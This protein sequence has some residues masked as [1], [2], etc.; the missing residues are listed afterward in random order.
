[1]VVAIL[2]RIIIIL[3]IGKHKTLSMYDVILASEIN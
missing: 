2:M 1:M 3:G